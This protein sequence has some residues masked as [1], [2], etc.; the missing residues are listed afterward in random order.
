[1]NHGEDAI[2]ELT[3]D[4]REVD[5][6]FESLQGVPTGRPERRQLLDRITIQLVRHAV[7]EEQYLYPEVRKRVPGGAE[8]AD[9]EIADHAAVER[10]LK[11]LESRRP[12]DPDFDTLVIRLIGEVTA[13][14][15]DEER[16]LFARLREVCPAER[17]EAL[18]GKI[19]RAKRAA[20]TRPHPGAPDTPPVNRLLDPGAGLV[21]RARDTLS[22]RGRL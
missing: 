11:D 7:A 10:L 6:L 4:H 17:L 5:E 2:A 12:V 15:H 9:K 22:G 21:D 8:L 14:I 16:H 1:M 20:P 3:A 18:G 19:R 13:H